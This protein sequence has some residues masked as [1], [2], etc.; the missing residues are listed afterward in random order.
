V[1]ITL[2]DSF[3]NPFVTSFKII[4]DDPLSSKNTKDGKGLKEE[5]SFNA[6]KKRLEVT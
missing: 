2:D 3:A 5:I 4:V 6:T 1:Y